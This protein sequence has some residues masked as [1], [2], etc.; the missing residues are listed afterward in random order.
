MGWG[1]DMGAGW[2]LMTGL[3]LVLLLAAI[4]LVVWILPHIRDGRKASQAPDAGPTPL[5]VLDHR[6]ARGELDIEA[7]RRLREELCRTAHTR[8]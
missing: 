1:S 4:A 3:W 8:R 7:Y 2:L 5:E 6:L